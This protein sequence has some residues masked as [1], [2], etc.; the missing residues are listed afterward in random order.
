TLS[1]VVVTDE[2]GEEWPAYLGPLTAW[3]AARH[4]KR[5]F[6]RWL[7]GAQEARAL[8]LFAL[9]HVV[10]AATMQHLASGNTV[11]VPQM[12]A[13]LAAIPMYREQNIL[14]DLVKRATA[15]V[16]DRNLVANANRYGR[17]ILGAHIERYLLD[18][19]R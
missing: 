12:L 5:F 13:S 1:H 18:A 6:V 15:L 16:I 11:A 8:G 10:P 7:S 4:S 2:R 9:P 14:V 17:P 3:L 19:M